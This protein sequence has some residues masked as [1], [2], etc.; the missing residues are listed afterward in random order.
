MATTTRQK[1]VDFI[2]GLMRHNSDALGF[3]PSTAIAGRWVEQGTY[4]LQKNRFGKP[5]GFLLHGNVNDDHTMYIHMACIEINKRNRG[6]G[7]A[8]V[9]HLIKRALRGRART[10][11]LR[12]AS[13]LDAVSFWQSCGFTPIGVTPGGTRRQR[14]IIQ[15]EMTLPQ[16]P[17][18]LDSG[19]LRDGLR[20]NG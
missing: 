5:V 7:K 2:C 18:R 11:L 16:T 8:A 15:Y 20:P 19:R 6:F 14:T 12:C 13:D 3:I 10:I 1:T 17:R 4:I 9:A